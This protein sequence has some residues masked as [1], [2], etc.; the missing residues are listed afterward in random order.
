MEKDKESVVQVLAHWLTML[1]LDAI[2]S[3]SQA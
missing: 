3:T 1:A 2:S